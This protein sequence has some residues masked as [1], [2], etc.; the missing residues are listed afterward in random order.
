MLW[1][2]FRAEPLTDADL[3]MALLGSRESWLI[4]PLAGAT[5]APVEPIARYG[6]ATLGCV[7][8]AADL[9]FHPARLSGV[10]IKRIIG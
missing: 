4:M 7:L 1:P 9:R 6:H 2:V 8:R 3:R 10:V 5:A